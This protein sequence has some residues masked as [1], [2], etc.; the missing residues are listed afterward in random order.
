[1]SCSCIISWTIKR[2]CLPSRN[3]TSCMMPA[4]FLLLSIA[5][6]RNMHFA[7]LDDRPSTGPIR[8]LPP[9]QRS[10]IALA[11]IFTRGVPM[12]IPLIVCPKHF[13]RLMHRDN[14]R[15][16]RAFRSTEMV[17]RMARWVALFKISRP[18]MRTPSA[19]GCDG[20]GFF[21]E[22][23]EERFYGWEAGGY[24]AD[25]HFD[26]LPDVYHQSWLAIAGCECRWL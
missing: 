6:L 26:D 22:R 8:H 25:V 15:V 4:L 2:F 21:E 3:T 16:V 7:R 19:A 24:N 11:T 20:A 10:L 12:H 5:E 13:P 17:Q 14:V 1:M 18:A 23:D 9:V